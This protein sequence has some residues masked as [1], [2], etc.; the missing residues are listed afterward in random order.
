[1]IGFNFDELGQA[2][3]AQE[4]PET[5]KLDKKELFNIVALTYF[6][7][8]LASRGVTREYLLAVRK[9][10]V[11][12]VET[13]TM[14]HFEVDLT[15]A[16]N[17]RIGTT[18]NGLLVRKLNGL[19]DDRGLNG[20]GF[21]ESEP[22]DQVVFDD[23]AWLFRIARYLDQTNLLEF[24]EAPVRQEPPISNSSTKISALYHGRMKA[25][26]YF[27][28]VKEARK[29]RKLW[30]QLK[31]ISE[32]YRNYLA[33]RLSVDVLRKE[34]EEAELRVHRLNSALEQLV[35]SASF[36]YSCLENPKL[37]TEMIIQSSDT[38]N[39]EIKDAISLNCRM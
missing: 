36:S 5:S 14:R 11:F 19:L 7:P 39:K 6:L 1:M 12:R 21:D 31:N 15:T 38:V 25:T 26:S 20:L 10:E 30:D 2:N 23:Q 18:N 16:M 4:D 9:N 24:F 28:R 8:P 33:Q 17:K 29:N 13:M 3:H 22:P 34:L 27:F 32:N 37:T 35:S